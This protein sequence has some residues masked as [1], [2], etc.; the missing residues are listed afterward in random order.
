MFITWS[1]ICLIKTETS[2]YILYTMQW[3]VCTQITTTHAHKSIDTPCELT[4]KKKRSTV[5]KRGISFSCT[6]QKSI[7]KMIVF[8][9][10]S[11]QSLTLSKSESRPITLRKGQGHLM[12]LLGLCRIALSVCY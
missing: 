11:G 9:F 10:H 12:N 5:G 6:T 2:S 8:F 7:H 4:T 1:R 3:R